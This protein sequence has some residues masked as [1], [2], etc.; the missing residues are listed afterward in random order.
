MQAAQEAGTVGSQMVKKI[1][2][3][4]ITEYTRNNRITMR[5]VQ[6]VHYI[7]MITVSLR[8]FCFSLRYLRSFAI[9]QRKILGGFL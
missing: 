8:W 1:C 6:T 2:S 5:H 4:G 9:I 3:V 7:A